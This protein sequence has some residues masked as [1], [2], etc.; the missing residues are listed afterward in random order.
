MTVHDCTKNLTKTLFADFGIANLINREGQCP[1]VKRTVVKIGGS[2]LL[3]PDLSSKLQQLVDQ[4]QYTDAR[5]SSK[6]ATPT[7]RKIL[8]IAGGGEL[9]DAMRNLDSKHVLAPVKLHW[10]CVQL[11]SHTAKI[12]HQLVPNTLWIDNDATL[13]EFVNNPIGL[14][15]AVVDIARFYHD[16][17]G[18]NL[19]KDWRTTT[20]SIAAHF[21]ADLAAEL[22]L[23]KSCECPSADVCWHEAAIAGYVDEAFP[24]IAPRV[25]KIVSLNF[26]S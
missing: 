11:L 2:L 4:L 3:L 16:A 18:W 23:L 13:A 7:N 9:I 25:P 19:P 10:S 21:A 14:S 15:A 6:L 1:N 8:F 20:D 22:Y 5:P 24:N 26:R 17:A 12:V